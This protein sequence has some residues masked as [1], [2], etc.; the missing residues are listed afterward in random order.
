MM[1]FFWLS[2]FEWF[3]RAQYSQFLPFTHPINFLRLNKKLQI[4]WT[5]V[6][7]ADK[8]LAFSLDSCCFYTETNIFKFPSHQYQTNFYEEDFFLSV[9][10]LLY[11]QE[12]KLERKYIGNTSRREVFV[13]LFPVLPN[14]HKCFHLTITLQAKDLCSMIATDADFMS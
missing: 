7:A 10:I 4:I 14:L 9:V 13:Q 11:K 2:I 12:L 5:S 8:S 3:K 6:T 1:Y